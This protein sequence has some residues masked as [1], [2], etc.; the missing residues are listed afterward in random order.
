MCVYTGEAVNGTDKPRGS[1]TEE[2]L[3]ESERLCPPQTHMLKSKL[4]KADGTRM[5]GPRVVFQIREWNP[6]ERNE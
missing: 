4:P 5:W 3:A 1:H 6:N 2:S